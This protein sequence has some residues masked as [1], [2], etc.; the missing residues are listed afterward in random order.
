MNYKLEFLFEISFKAGL[1]FPKE[2]C[3]TVPYVCST[4]SKF[5]KL[6]IWSCPSFLILHN[7]ILFIYSYYQYIFQNFASRWSEYKRDANWYVAEI[8]AYVIANRSIKKLFLKYKPP[9]NYTLAK[10]ELPHIEVCGVFAIIGVL[11]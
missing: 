3:S 6:V 10:R 5:C 2:I 4:N 8:Y 11:S 9:P 1:L 7:W